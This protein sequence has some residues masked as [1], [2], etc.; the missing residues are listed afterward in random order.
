MTTLWH[1]SSR[2]RENRVP[3]CG[4]WLG[5]DCFRRRSL[6]TARVTASRHCPQ[7]CASHGVV[8]GDF[9]LG[10]RFGKMNWWPDRGSL[11]GALLAPPLQLVAGEDGDGVLRLQVRGRRWVAR[12]QFEDG[13]GLRDC[14]SRG[15]VSNAWTNSSMDQRGDRRQPGGGAL[16]DRR[17]VACCRRGGRSCR[18]RGRSR[19]W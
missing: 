19:G 1:A 17:G 13:D 5:R 8:S 3:A 15:H 2:G 11:R 9:E 18:G 14:S 16:R 7:P 4:Q 12:L 10:G 6:A